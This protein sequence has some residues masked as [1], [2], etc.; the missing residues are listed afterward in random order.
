MPLNRCPSTDRLGGVTTYGYTPGGQVSALTDAENQVTL[1]D[2]NARG[3]KIRETYPDHVSGA[4]V[5]T[6]GYGI[7]QFSYDPAGRIRMKTDQQG[8]T[9]TFTYNLAGQLLSRAYRTAANSPSGTVAD[10]DTFTYDRAGRMLT[11]LSGRYANTVT[12]AYDHAGRLASEGLT[13]AGQTYSVGRTYD[14]RGLEATLSYPGG[15]VVQRSYT[16]RR[17]L[18]QTSYLGAVVESRT[19]DAAG[20]HAT[21]TYGNAAVTTNSYRLDNLLASRATSHA[22]SEQLGTYSY[23]WDANKNKTAET[24]GAQ[25]SGF[26]FS[27]PAGGY[28]Q[29]DRLTAWNRTDGARNQSWTLSA[30]GDWTAHSDAGV[31]QTRTH[32]GAHE[33]TALTTGGTTSP[34]SY[35]PKGNLL[36]RPAALASPALGLV[37]DFDNRLRGADTN[38]SPATQEVTFEYDALGR[39]V[40]RSEAGNNVVYVHAG[41]QVIADYARGAAAAAPSFRYVYGSYVDEP[42]L[43]HAGTGTTLPTSGTAALYYHRNQQYSIVGLSDAAGTLVERYAYT[44]YGELTILAPD[45]TA[46][47]TSSFENRYTYTGREWDPTLRLYHFRARWLEPKAGRFIGRDPLGYVDGM[48]LYGAYLGLSNFDPSGGQILIP[49][50]SDR[51]SFIKLLQL[52]CPRA[53]AFG[54]TG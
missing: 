53:I 10:S 31:S 32:A 54:T 45:R 26:G 37:W 48:G 41:Q 16:P 5:G 11:A 40:A 19:Y 28:D 38:G 7:V 30:V 52:L 43:R 24:I 46:R 9:C 20:R 36:S 50:E 14:V 44:A 33:L 12:L 29:E 34:L 47:A 4:A 8:D 35:D 39:R 6:A 3:E 17:Q 49:N 27:V 42:L 22:G 25:G 2:Y 13:I 1:Y 23:S 51:D 15:A 21:S 18:Q